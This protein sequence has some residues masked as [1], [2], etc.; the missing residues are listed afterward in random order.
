MSRYRPRSPEKNYV[1]STVSVQK[2]T[3]EVLRKLAATKELTFS[4][5]VDKILTSY[6]KKQ[7]LL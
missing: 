2:G 7:A 1:R 6:C 3:D 4:H 5:L